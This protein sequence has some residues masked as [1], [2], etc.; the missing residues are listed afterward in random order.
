MSEQTVRR[1]DI[2]AGTDGSTVGEALDESK[3]DTL[4]NILNE[5]SSEV[6][7]VCNSAQESMVVRND[8][9]LSVDS[10]IN[11]LGT[12]LTALEANESVD[13]AALERFTEEI[14]DA[15]KKLGQAS[16]DTATSK[17]SAV[18]LEDRLAV[19]NRTGL[20]SLG[21]VEMV[22]LEAT[23]KAVNDLR[24][25]LVSGLNAVGYATDQAMGVREL[26]ASPINA[27]SKISNEEQR[28]YIV[29]N[30]TT[31]QGGLKG[32]MGSRNDSEDKILQAISG[33]GEHS[34]QES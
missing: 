5:L 1:H 18:R 22:G 31:I 30:L 34:K 16:E 2:Q 7:R 13:E 19:A 33:L 15:I 8:A 32:L 12:I 24:L 17:A 4:I 10:M 3:T 25:N 23:L 21:E 20:D 28:N 6:S 29:A 27:A 11:E 9:W 26:L 14:E